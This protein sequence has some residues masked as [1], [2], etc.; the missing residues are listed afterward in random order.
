MVLVVLIFVLMGNNSIKGVSAMK[1]ELN[2]FYNVDCMELMAEIPD[3]YFELA[4]VDVPY[5][6]GEENMRQEYPKQLDV[7]S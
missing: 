7:H 2:G 4:I 6:I 5:G 3:K 1:Y